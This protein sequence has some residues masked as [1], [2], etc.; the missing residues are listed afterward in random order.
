MD[1]YLAIHYIGL[2]F[3]WA[4]LLFVP[5]A[6][7]A[8]ILVPLFYAFRALQWTPLAAGVS[9][10]IALV[11]MAAI[12]YVQLKKELADFHATCKAL[13]SAIAMAPLEQPITDIYIEDAE[14]REKIHKSLGIDD[15]P[16]KRLPGL[17]SFERCRGEQNVRCFRYSKSGKDGVTSFREQVI[18]QPASPKTFSV[19]VTEAP[20][21][22]LLPLY[23]VNYS[24]REKTSKRVLRSA[25]EYVQTL[26]LFGRYAEWLQ[27]A[28][29]LDIGPISPISACGYVSTVPG[30]FL[31][32]N[33][34][35]AYRDA[36]LRMLGFDEK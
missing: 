16:F 23:K 1:L 12:G 20:G 29:L 15:E 4:A 27:Y 3:I 9:A 26:G 32:S 28:P 31:R 24:I 36:D 18:S 17:N 22:R 25:T 2:A 10:S 6:I 13:P 34:N 5:L 19:F 14:L 21:L 7:S 11:C 8:L 35:P 33:A 30:E